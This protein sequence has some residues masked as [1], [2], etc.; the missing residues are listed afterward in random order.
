[1]TLVVTQSVRAMAKDGGQETKKGR[2]KPR[3]GSLP[4]KK[5]PSPMATWIS[6]D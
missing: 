6:P 4:P 2:T 1:M 3:I 5:D